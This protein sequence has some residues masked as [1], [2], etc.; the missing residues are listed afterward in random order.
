RRGAK[1]RWKCTAALATCAA[2]SSG[3]ASATDAVARAISEQEIALRHRQHLGRRAGEQ[4]AVGGD[5]V[6]FRIDLNVG[7]RA[8][9]H[10]AFLADVARVLDGNQLL[11]DP[12]LV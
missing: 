4:F 12:E 1:T 3:S 9:V 5:L 6:G 8:V 2:R 10:H 11:L 7:R